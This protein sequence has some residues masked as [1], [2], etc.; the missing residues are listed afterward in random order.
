MTAPDRQAAAARLSAPAAPEVRWK[1]SR[2]RLF[3]PAARLYGG[4]S[5]GAV[6]FLDPDVAAAL[7]DQLTA[8]LA[9]NARPSGPVPDVLRGV[10]Q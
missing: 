3:L 8:V 4:R 1:N 5:G 10:T 6:V 7:R 9:E 2:V